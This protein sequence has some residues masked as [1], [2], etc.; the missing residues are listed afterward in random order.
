MHKN[1]N[2]VIDIHEAKE[3]G[4]VLLEEG[5]LAK[6]N[7]ADVQGNPVIN[8]T[9]DQ[10][11][12]QLSYQFIYFIVCYLERYNSF[13][14]VP[15]QFK[16]LY[17]E[18]EQCWTNKAVEMEF[19]IPLIGFYTDEN[20]IELTEN[21]NIERFTAED[22]TAFERGLSIK[23]YHY[24][25]RDYNNS[26]FKISSKFVSTQEN[27]YEVP[28][29]VVDEFYNQVYD[30]LTSIR[31]LQQG[32]VGAFVMVLKTVKPNI[33]YSEHL[34]YPLYEFML[35][36]RGLVLNL[37]SE[38]YLKKENVGNLIELFRIMINNGSKIKALKGALR[39]YNQAYSRL[40]Y[41]D[42]IVDYTIVLE[43]TLLFGTPYELRYKLALYGAI[44][45]AWKRNP[46]KIFDTLQVLY[47]IRS[48]VVHENKSLEDLFR[49]ENSDI[50]KAI[51]RAIEPQRPDSITL[52]DE[53][54]RKVDQ[55]VRD[56][57]LEYIYI[58]NN[59][60]PIEQINKKMEVR[61]ICGIPKT[62]II[63]DEY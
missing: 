34:V 62:R 42:R 1:S 7:V 58:L 61:L 41:E 63:N 35:P 56:V 57:L 37:A 17:N 53:T 54:T 59:G 48:K 15:K 21:I 23:S 5:I 55:I 44:L 30:C 11:W 32:R 27:A 49:K 52:V 45:L 3:A 47:D 46:Q 9:L 60:I 31:L 38:Y 22:K 4:Q 29:K 33:I 50:G 19:V 43:N 28:Q 13:E 36:P 12:P 40:S 10:M 18:F 2:E 14:F 25:S 6:P 8:P 24:D 51:R 20:K 26:N 16:K 39:R